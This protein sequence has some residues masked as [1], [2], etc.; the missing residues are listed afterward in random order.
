MIA[1]SLLI[2][3]LACEAG[4]VLFVAKSPT[5]PDTRRRRGWR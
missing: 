4:L 1:I 3:I 2:T 5:R